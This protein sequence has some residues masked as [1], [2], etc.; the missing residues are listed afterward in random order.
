MLQQGRRLAKPESQAFFADQPIPIDPGEQDFRLSR[1]VKID[2]AKRLRRQGG[3][4]PTKRIDVLGPFSQ[5]S[6]EEDSAF[7]RRIFVPL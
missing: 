4:T 6:R 3:P 7:G 5:Q 1:L 2:F